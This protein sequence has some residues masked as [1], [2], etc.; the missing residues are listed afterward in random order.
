MSRPL[1]IV[2]GPFAA[3]FASS[4]ERQTS[5]QDRRLWRITPGALCAVGVLLFLAGGRA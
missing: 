1:M 5:R 3:P 2:G 4:Q